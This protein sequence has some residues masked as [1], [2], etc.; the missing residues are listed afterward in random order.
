MAPRSWSPAAAP[1]GADQLAELAWLRCGGLVERHPAE[2]ARYGRSAGFR[3]NT[4]MVAAGADICLAFIQDASPGATHT[5]GLAEAAGIPTHR[6][7]Q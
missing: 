1:R 7:T 4:E 6:Y 2:W 3:R 5:A